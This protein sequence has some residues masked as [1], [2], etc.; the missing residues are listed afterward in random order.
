MKASAKALA[1]L[2]LTGVL[3]VI[4]T[5]CAS[6]GR[7]LV[8]KV[9][10]QVQPGMARSQVEALLGSPRTRET[11]PDGREFVIYSY[12]VAEP[13]M[14]NDL[15]VEFPD[16]RLGSF[17]MAGTLSWRML[18]A[19]YTR[20]G[21]VE[22]V[23]YSTSRSPYFVEVDQFFDAARRQWV[24][25]EITPEILGSIK[26]DLT[27]GAELELMLGEPTWISFQP[28]GRSVCGWYYELLVG[29][30]IPRARSHTLIAVLDD[31]RVVRDFSRLDGIEMS[32]GPIQ[33]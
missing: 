15:T 2:L 32:P 31:D 3:V 5:G 23:K 33:R 27:T 24:G 11:T 8:P 18:T 10:Q 29:R 13:A 12:R 25:T 21:N 1:L 7:R 28:G 30:N 6:A 17:V 14:R 4:S 16:K 20:E 19:L 26:K 9:A 22:R